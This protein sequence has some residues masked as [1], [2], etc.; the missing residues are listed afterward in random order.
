MRK[1]RPQTSHTKFFVAVSVSAIWDFMCL[2]NSTL[3]VKLSS[4]SLQEYGL[5]LACILWWIFNVCFKVHCFPQISQVN[6]L[7][8]VCTNMWRLRFVRYIN[9]FPHSLHLCFFFDDL[10]Q[11]KSFSLQLREETWIFLDVALPSWSTSSCRPKAIFSALTV[12][13]LKILKRG[14]LLMSL[15][16]GILP[17]SYLLTPPFNLET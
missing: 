8:P 14:I 17:M 10:T 16:S 6:G 9:C 13:L 12:S 15:R 11:N 4:H 1:S 7:I 5:P 2:F 3:S